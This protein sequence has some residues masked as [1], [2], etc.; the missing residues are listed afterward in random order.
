MALAIDTQSSKWGTPGTDDG[1][2]I[3]R[4]ATTKLGFFGKTPVAQPAL[5]TDAATIIAALVAL[6]L[7]KAA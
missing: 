1:T 4:N 2:L 3:G 6:G 5:P 7:V